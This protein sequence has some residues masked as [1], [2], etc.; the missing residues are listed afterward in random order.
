M[1]LWQ[2]LAAL[3]L[4]ALLVGIFVALRQRG[5]G[6]IVVS[7]IVLAVG[8]GAGAYWQF[9]ILVAEQARLR[10]LLAQVLPHHW[11]CASDHACNRF[12]NACDPQDSACDV[13]PSVGS[14]P[15]TPN[16]KALPEN[17]RMVR[18]VRA[19]IHGLGP[20][21]DMLIYSDKRNEN[22]GYSFYII[23]ERD[24]ARPTSYH[25]SDYV[26]GRFWMIYAE[27]GSPRSGALLQV[28]T[29]SKEAPPDAVIVTRDFQPATS[30]VVRYEAYDDEIAVLNKWTSAGPTF[31]RNEHG[32]YDRH[33]WDSPY[34]WSRW[35]AQ[36]EMVCSQPP[37][38]AVP[39]RWVKKLPE[40]L[41]KVCA[42]APA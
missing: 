7:I 36:V 15:F 6:L 25:A 23:A 30:E 24:K 39:E 13:A 38:T 34:I 14:G 32:G 19:K 37:L 1:V 11:Q 16:P 20:L 8:F 5:I 40:I 33:E 27:G 9:R 31:T 22:H 21:H 4:L 26:H 12:L 2:A 42:P 10:M 28:S 18:F 3:A 29:G 17:D 41:P 35:T